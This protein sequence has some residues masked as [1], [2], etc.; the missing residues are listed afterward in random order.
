MN[1][2][3]DNL[4]MISRSKQLKDENS[5]HAKYP[6]EVRTLIQ[7]KGALKRQINKATRKNGS[8]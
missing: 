5:L 2:D 8:N 7:L 1:C 3:V 4:Y 6:A